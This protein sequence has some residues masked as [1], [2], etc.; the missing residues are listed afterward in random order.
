MTVSSLEY[1][2]SIKQSKLNFCGDG[3][4]DL[5]GIDDIE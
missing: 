4:L 5:D 1:K 3:V 2:E